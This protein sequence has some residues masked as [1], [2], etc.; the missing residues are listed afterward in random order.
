[1][2]DS[3]CLICIDTGTT[4]TRIW[5]MQGDQILAR[6]TA[7]VGVRDSAKDGTNERLR[8]ALRELISNVRA[9]AKAKD[10]R[11]DCVIAAGMITSSLGLAD[12]PH[13]AAPAGIAE[14]A[15]ATRVHHF[16]DITDLPV[17]L[18]PGVRSGQM[19]CDLTT[20]GEADLMRGEETLCVGLSLLGLVERPST[21]LN[22]GSHWKAI[23]L[24]A[25]GCIA[26]SITSIS[27]EMIHTTQTQTILASAVPHERPEYIDFSWLSAGIQ[28]QRQSGLARTLFCVRLLEQ[29]K[30]GSPEDRLSFLIGAF[31]AADMDTLQA[32]G[33]FSN[34]VVIIGG[35]ALA[36]AWQWALAQT[37][38]QSQ[39]I[40]SEESE[41]ALLAGLRQIVLSNRKAETQ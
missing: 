38:L 15:A 3:F 26:A 1:M 35:G 39:L 28:R 34:S 7:Q 29:S 10:A 19:P 14:L 8:A 4:N 18:V 24:D 30:Q 5:L 37:K 33:A 27:G 36:E 13:I 21:I 25:A 31:I 11:P 9:E 16:P 22:L 23:Q 41:R 6:A 20:A 2:S 12:V 32:A 40:S 17:L